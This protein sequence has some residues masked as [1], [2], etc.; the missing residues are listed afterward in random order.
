MLGSKAMRLAILSVAAGFKPK[1]SSHCLRY[2]EPLPSALRIEGALEAPLIGQ[3]RPSILTY[4]LCI[5]T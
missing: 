2:D 1:E 4:T 5:V 3:V